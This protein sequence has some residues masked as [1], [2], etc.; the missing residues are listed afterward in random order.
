MPDVPTIAVVD[1]N[2]YNNAS[3][4]E[5]LFT[6]SR[7]EL[8]VEFKRTPKTPITISVDAV[9]NTHGWS[10]SLLVALGNNTTAKLNGM[11]LYV[12]GPF[13]ESSTSTSTT[14]FPNL[15]DADATGNIVTSFSEGNPGAFNYFEITDFG[16]NDP[17]YMINPK[18]EKSETNTFIT[19]NVNK[20]ALTTNS[21]VIFEMD[22]AT[23]TDFVNQLKILNLNRTSSGGYGDGPGVPLQNYLNV[24]DDWAHI[25]IVFDYAE[26][27]THVFVNGL[28]VTPKG[29]TT[30]RAMSDVG[31]NNIGT[32]LNLSGFRI[33][34]GVG[35]DLSTAQSTLIDN[36]SVK[37]F[38]D[39]TAAGD[40]ESYISVKSA[41]GY[42]NIET[43]RSGEALPTVATVNGVAYGNV[44]TANKA[45]A[46][47][48]DLYVTLEKSTVSG[49]TISAPA[50][51]VSNGLDY[52]ISGALK[53][54][55][56]TGDVIIITAVGNI[57]VSV[58]V[59]GT[60]VYDGDVAPGTDINKIL[61]EYGS[62]GN[63]VAGNGQIFTDVSWSKA[64]GVATVDTEFVGNGTK[65]KELFYVYDQNGAKV[66]TTYTADNFR[67]LIAEGGGKI[68]SFILNGNIS[69]ASGGGTPYSGQRNVYLNGY[70]LS[71]KG[72]N[73][74]L[75]APSSGNLT[76]SGPGTIS[77]MNHTSTHYFLMGSYE[78]TGVCTF[79]NLE[80]NLSSGL[81]NLRG[82]FMVLENCTVNALSIFNAP[83]LQVG[84][85]YNQ[86][87]TYIATSLDIIDSYIN[88]RSYAGNT[89]L[90]KEKIVSGYKGGDE[91]LPLTDPYH[92]VNISGSTIITEA[93]LM[94][95]HET[96]T[97]KDGGYTAVEAGDGVVSNMSLNIDNST[98]IASSVWAGPKFLASV[99]IGNNTKINSALNNHATFGDVNIADGVVATKSNDHLADVTYT[100]F[101]ANVTWSNGTTEKWAHGSTPVAPNALT[102]VDKVVGKNNY[103]FYDSYEEAPF[104]LSGNLTL[105][106]DIAFNIYTGYEASID[107][108]IVNGETLTASE[109]LI[110]GST[111]VWAYTVKLDPAYAAAQFDIIFK[112]SDGSTIVRAMSV[113]NY[114][115]LVYANSNNTAE[116]KAVVS[117]T[118]NYI[119]ATSVYF[120]VNADL[121]AINSLLSANPAV[122]YDLPT[123][124]DTNA[125]AVNAYVTSIQLNVMST[126][127]FRFNLADGVDG[128]SVVIKVNGEKKETIVTGSYVELELRAYEMTSVIT[129]EYSSASGT[130]D[131]AYYCAAVMA[132]KGTSGTAARRY[133]QIYVRGGML[134][135]IFS[136]AMA[137]SVYKATV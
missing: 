126:L 25:A 54:T 33:N 26:D 13:V 91:N 66:D 22:V 132:N 50:T 8:D 15:K 129:I 118:L 103:R 40:I 84:E 93:A 60:V 62:V 90:I 89:T 28:L 88:Y 115:S 75:S 104:Y 19:V 131:L 107:A 59:N 53:I 72:G 112:M 110:G 70:E 41:A 98:V 27:T 55:S 119:K 17:Y 44:N 36:V 121:S 63:V 136:Y 29:T 46:I 61:A 99:N 124:S 101:Y 43:G 114:A 81:A 68:R 87:Y 78:T 7:E 94:E 120:G 77:D 56:S 9:I 37:Y 123:A 48:S 130:T 116:A 128:N 38:A 122:G 100:S 30:P 3:E 65:Y 82:G 18:V 79:K 86:G 45:I 127:R 64:P 76:V 6:T 42:A 106:S 1:G 57:H 14:T 71:Y 125:S 135:A 20:K 67:T 32:D 73:H 117:N 134:N 12:E 11:T 51:L 49:V 58:T 133:E 23:E 105:G 80:M 39:N 108:V 31:K 97:W 74:A 137:A 111:L 5:E 96:A 85:Q 24:S 2:N 52:S 35:V 95:S 21:Y 34:M 47:G 16:S 83:L 92:T 102:K 4:L 69:V 109:K 10:E 113:A